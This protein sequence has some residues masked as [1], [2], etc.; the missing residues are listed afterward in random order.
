M[1]AH[2][3]TPGGERNARGDGAKSSGMTVAEAGR[4]GGN[5][6]SERH[7]RNFYATIG[8]KGGKARSARLQSEGSEESA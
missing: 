8:R 6:T 2:K 3:A 7:G 4:R 1:A 5:T